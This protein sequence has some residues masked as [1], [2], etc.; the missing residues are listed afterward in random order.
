M[1]YATRTINGLLIIHYITVLT[2]QI[3]D[4]L[5]SQYNGETAIHSLVLVNMC[6][7]NSMYFV[8]VC[9]CPCSE[10]EHICS[11][12]AGPFAHLEWIGKAGLG[13][14]IGSK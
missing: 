2:V 10:Q 12:V 4:V 11:T 5:D 14:I 1:Y 7:I 8:R 13:S 3:G 9:K 6:V